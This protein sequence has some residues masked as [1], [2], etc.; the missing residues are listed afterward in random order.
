VSQ[1]AGLSLVTN[2][3][4]MPEDETTEAPTHAEVLEAAGEAR[5][6][7]TM[8]CIVRQLCAAVDTA[9]LPELPVAAHFRGPAAAAAAAA[10]RAAPPAEA[11]LAGRIAALEA[12]LAAVKALAS[13]VAA[14]RA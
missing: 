4:V 12:E 8:Q 5:I 13:T 11:Q 7:D 14:A 10:G 3:G 6:K 1:V 9:A 2:K